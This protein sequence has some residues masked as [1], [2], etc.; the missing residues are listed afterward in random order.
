MNE[1]ASEPRQADT[2]DPEVTGLL[3]QI[4]AVIM[5]ARSLAGELTEKEFNWQPASR[6]WSVG[7]C[8]QHITLTTQLYAGNIQPMVAT[9]RERKARGERPYR[10]GVVSRWFVRSM[11]PPPSMRIRTFAKVQPAPHLDRDQTLADFEAVHRTLV[12]GLDGVDASLLRQARMPSPFV[13]LLQ[14]TL[15]QVYG[16]NLAHARRHLWQA[17]QVA[18]ESAFGS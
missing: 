2:R 1:T 14:F 3:E 10:E 13:S 18:T 16:L 5:D 9:A 12:A 11:E 6:R 17:R 8:L 7:Q 4:D 15:G